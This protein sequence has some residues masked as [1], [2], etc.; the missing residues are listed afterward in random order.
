MIGLQIPMS[1]QG[2]LS[3]IIGLWLKIKLNITNKG[4]VKENYLAFFIVIILIKNL[5]KLFKIA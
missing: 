3:A 4:K 5:I 2:K 1:E